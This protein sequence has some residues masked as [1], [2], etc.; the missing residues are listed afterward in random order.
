MA[1]P[2]LKARA[3]TQ[4]QYGAHPGYSED[5]GYDFNAS[6][7]ASGDQFYT[8]TG[9]TEADFEC[10]FRV[11]GVIGG[12]LANVHAFAGL[13][14]VDNTLGGELPLGQALVFDALD[15]NDLGAFDQPFTIRALLRPGQHFYLS[16]ALSANV[17]RADTNSGE[18]DAYNTFTSALTAGDAS[19]LR[20]GFS[21]AG[22]VPEPASLALVGLALTAVGAVRRR[23]PRAPAAHD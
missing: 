19:L 20:I 13:F 1:T 12:S 16:A 3:R 14:D 8:Y 17:G 5:G 7:V 22:Q 18:A 21:D 2:E 4:A 23:R 10:T 11:D 6:A 9:A 15:I